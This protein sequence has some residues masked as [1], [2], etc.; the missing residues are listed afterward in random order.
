MQLWENSRKNL[1][2]NWSPSKVGSV[3]GLTLYHTIPSFIDPERD[4]FL[5]N[6]RNRRK[7][8]K[9]VSSPYPT[10]FSIFLKSNFCFSIKFVSWSANAALNQGLFGKGLTKHPPNFNDLENEAFWKH[11][12]KGENP[13]DHHFLLFLQFLQKSIRRVMKKRY[14]MRRG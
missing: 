12:G 9:P 5:I 8:C 14:C 3:Y 7:C 2:C 10:M 13:D 1:Q 4:D 11:C 6:C